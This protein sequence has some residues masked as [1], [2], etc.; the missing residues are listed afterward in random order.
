MAR[1]K[2]LISGAG[3]AGPALAWWL[4]RFGFE[5]SIV[6]VAPEFRSGGYMVDFWGKG[7]DIIDRMGLLP[8]VFERGYHVRNI[9]FVHSDGSP[10]GGFSTAPFWNATDGRFTS[11]PRTDLARTMWDDLPGDM[12][13]R[14]DDEIATIEQDS[15]GVNVTFASGAEERV[16]LVVGADG[17][18]S[19]VR[20]VLFGPEE[21]FETFLGYAFAACTITGYARRTPDAY[22]GYG[23]PGRM[24]SRVSMRE[25]RTLV[26]FIWR[27]ESFT[28]PQGEARRALL[29]DRFDG[30]G[31][32]TDELL[33]A[34]DGSDDLYL[35]RMSQIHLPTW[36]SGRVALVGD[37]AWA[38]SFLA[39]EGSG[40]GIIGAYV[41]AGELHR[42]GGD[43]SAFATYECRLRAMIESK[44]KMAS[45]FGGAFAPKTRLGLLFR[46]WVASLLDVGPIGNLAIASTLK[47]NID[48]PDYSA[49]VAG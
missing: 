35:D 46:N 39:G 8:Q 29:R 47:G 9:C 4:H 21:K 37:A 34:L 40:L 19:R 24:V 13:K 38:P 49:E 41:L 48:L 22:V 25:D 33:A 27:D 12:P 26:L 20:E 2:V 30:I 17:L 3:V 5:P 14:L 23:V 32:E 31:W 45:K 28:P 1:K 36:S 11:I 10:A 44:Q 15:E 43:P 7:L 16:D 6:E 42:S 18:H